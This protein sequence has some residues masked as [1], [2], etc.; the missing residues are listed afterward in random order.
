[1]ASAF[2]DEAIDDTV[3]ETHILIMTEII[4]TNL[5]TRQNLKELG[6][7]LDNKISLLES[8]LTIKLGTIISIAIGVAVTLS[9]LV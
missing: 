6:V 9:K 4:E 2:S 1:M 8:R 7:D 5:A 3:N